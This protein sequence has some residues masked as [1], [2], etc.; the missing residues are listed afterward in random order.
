MLRRL[1]LIFISSKSKSIILGLLKLYSKVKSMLSTSLGVAMIRKFL[2]EDFSSKWEDNKNNWMK[3]GLLLAMFLKNSNR[4]RRKIL[5]LKNNLKIK[6][7]LIRDR[8][9]NNLN[10]SKNID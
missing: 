5:N 7:E 9:H 3:T 6:K 10:N 8:N 2:Q 4:Y 1:S